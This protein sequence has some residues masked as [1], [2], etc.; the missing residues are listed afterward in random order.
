MGLVSDGFRTR[1]VPNQIGLISVS[2]VTDINKSELSSVIDNAD[3]VE[4]GKNCYASVI[5]ISK[6]APLVPLTLVSFASL[7]F[8]TQVMVAS[9]AR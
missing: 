4:T 8:L 2:S 6:V 9:P 7:T 5:D 3:V 1:S